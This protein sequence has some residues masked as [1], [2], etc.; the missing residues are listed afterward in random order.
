MKSML[1]TL[2]GLRL[3]SLA[4]WTALSSKQPWLHRSR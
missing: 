2:K 4:Q 1:Y 3:K